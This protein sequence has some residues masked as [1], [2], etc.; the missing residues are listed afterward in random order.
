MKQITSTL[1]ALISRSCSTVFSFFA[2][3]PRGIA[4]R[5]SERLITVPQ[6]IRERF[7]RFACWFSIDQRHPAG[8]KS[9]GRLGF[10]YFARDT[11]GI[12]YTQS[13][14]RNSGCLRRT[15]NPKATIESSAVAI[16]YSPAG[17][18][19]AHSTS[20]LSFVSRLCI[21][22]KMVR[23]V[24]C[25]RNARVIL[26]SSSSS[27]PFCRAAPRR[28]YRIGPWRRKISLVGDFR[29]LIFPEMQ[30]I[31]EKLRGC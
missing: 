13:R 2:A 19:R 20:L 9:H 12:P 8:S 10:V 15:C 3:I 21:K 29:R 27:S 31:D 26:S 22:F 18:Q 17:M 14:Y 5:C 28:S 1:F 30:R 25:D 7:N 4:V 6:A 16:V 24:V 23:S 11:H